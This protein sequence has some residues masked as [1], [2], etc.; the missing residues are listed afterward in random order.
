MLELLV[1]D[2]LDVPVLLVEALNIEVLLLECK[3]AGEAGACQRCAG[4][5][6]ACAGD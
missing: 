4:G 6:C 5:T 2:V 3:T 1:V